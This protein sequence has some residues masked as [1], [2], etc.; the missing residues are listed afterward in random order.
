MYPG[1][2]RKHAVSF[3]RERGPRWKYCRRGTGAQEA[4]NATGAHDLFRKAADGPWR[5]R[6]STRTE[7]VSVSRR[8]EERQPDPRATRREEFY[9]AADFLV[10]LAGA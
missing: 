4:A 1:A 10:H 6:Y 8:R 7:T 3:R 9:G 5:G 2:K